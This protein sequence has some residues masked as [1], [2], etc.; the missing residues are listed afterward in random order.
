MKAPAVVDANGPVAWSV[1]IAITCLI[2]YLCGGLLWLIIPLLLS[3]ILYY[4]TR[5]MVNRLMRR[6]Y[7]QAMAV[8][9]VIFILVIVLGAIGFWFFPTLTSQ[10]EAVQTSSGRYIH[11][12]VELLDSTMKATEETLPFM[13]EMT[14]S[15]NERSWEEQ[16]T[17][18]AEKYLGAILL[19]MLHWVPSLL[20]VPYLTYF[21]LLDGARFKRFI[22]RSIPNAYFEKVLLLFHRVDAQVQAYF[23]GLIG[24]TA[25][26]AISYLIGMLVLGFMQEMSFSSLVFFSVLL[27]VLAWIPYIGS[28]VGAVL[29]VL[30]A[31]TDF[32]NNDWIAYGAIIMFVIVRLLDDFVYMPVTVGRS[33]KMHPVVMVLMLLVG[34]EVA[35]IT[36]LLLVMPVL[37]VVMVCGEI[38]GGVLTDDRLRARQEHSRQLHRQR[39]TAG[40]STSS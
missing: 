3:V 24:L 10:V 31:A 20:L 22:V 2:L 18:L 28:I 11:G 21:L 14:G 25:L 38:I 12:G 27:A 17:S 5:P 36:G 15:L 32:P 13:A 7:T 33:L 29:L 35:G 8:N 37:G 1:I 19:E 23:Q 30:V 40:L 26:D 4:L 39:A 34:A 16:L 9:M 6:G